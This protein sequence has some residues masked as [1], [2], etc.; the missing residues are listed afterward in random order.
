ML[1]YATKRAETPNVN[2][3]FDCDQHLKAAKCEKNLC[4]SNVILVHWSPQKIPVF[5]P[6][7]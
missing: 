4:Y 5:H 3:S 2:A 7:V 1:N 6:L